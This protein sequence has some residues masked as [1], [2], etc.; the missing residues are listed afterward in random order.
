LVISQILIGESYGHYRAAGLSGYCRNAMGCT[1]G[2][3]LVS[4][5]LNF[6]TADFHPGNDLP[7]ILFLPTHATAWYQRLSDELE[8]A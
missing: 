5:I 4:S 1:I 8:K 2:I 7:Y 6:Q 3:M